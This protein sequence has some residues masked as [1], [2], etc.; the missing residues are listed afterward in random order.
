MTPDTSNN[1]DA[2]EFKETS[3][4]GVTQCLSFHLI[5]GALS[6]YLPECKMIQQTKPIYFCLHML[7]VMPLYIDL[8]CIRW[9]VYRYSV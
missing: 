1:E 5:K 4:H 9:R 8:F 2:P 6:P 7:H 3:S